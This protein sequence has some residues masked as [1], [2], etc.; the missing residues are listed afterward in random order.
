MIKQTELIPLAPDGQKR[1]ADSLVSEKSQSRGVRACFSFPVVLAALLTLL[2]VFT[3]RSRFSDP[4]MWWH[5]KTGEIIWETHSIP[6]TDVFSYTTDH[7]AYTPHE[8]LSQLTIYAAYHLGG[9]SGLMLW[10][11]ILASLIVVAG[12]LLCWIYSGN[13]KI[14]FVGALGIWLFATVGLSV[15]PQMIGYLL[16]V[17]ELLILS[18][19][20]RHNIKWLFTLPVLFALWVNCHGSFLLGFLVLGAVLFCG[21]V[22]FRVGSLVCERFSKETRIVLVTS[23]VL[24]LAALFVNPV[25]LSQLTYPFNTMFAQHTG[26][27][28]SSEWQAAPL[29]DARLWCLF[30]TTGL[31]LL[32]PLMRTIE[33]RLEEL[34]LAGAAFVLAVQH[35]RML[36]VFG[37]MALP[38]LCRLLGTA[39]DTYEP[40]RDFLG[41]NVAMIVLAVVPMI[42][43]FPS[44][45]DLAEQVKKAN[46]VRA[47][48][49]ISRSGL[50][51]R[52]LND[53]IYGGYLIWAAPERKVFVDGR[54]DVYEWT[55]VLDDYMD[56]VNIRENP[57]HLLE[58]YKVDFCLLSRE[59]P[60]I[61]VLRL[62]AGWKEV[63]ADETSVVFSRAVIAG[64]TETRQ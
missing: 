22:E 24:S 46:P 21:I 55:G 25:G 16:L 61:N 57:I 42:L 31:I 64:H 30:G 50:T 32:I 8:W 59:E 47:I 19:G 62:L 17:A 41:T 28:Y 60:I 49:Y 52:M 27:K 51:G 14:A 7:H 63:Y 26:L 18:I 38:I 6:T 58:K 29:T 9:Y 1:L 53:Y 20:R 33:L 39:W 43:S 37:I 48:E 5:L 10:L 56:W 4:D 36:F 23:T 34:L 54:A 11:C 13:A 3:V 2:C 12:Y 44:S 45:H 40:A 35:E 15:R